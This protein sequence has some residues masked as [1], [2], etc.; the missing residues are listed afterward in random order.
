MSGIKKGND[1]VNLLPPQNE[2]KFDK[3]C[4]TFK[5]INENLFG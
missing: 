2:H 1:K 4:L 3:L 5:R